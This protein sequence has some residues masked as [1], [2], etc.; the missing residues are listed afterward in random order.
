MF[1]RRLAVGFLAVG[2]LTQQGLA[3][4]R[5]TAGVGAASSPLSGG[6]KIPADGT[7]AESVTSGQVA[8]LVPGNPRNFLIGGDFGQNLWQRGLVVTAGGAG[9]LLADRWFATGAGLVMSRDTVA[10][11]LP[12]DVAA[13]GK[14]MPGGACIA[15]VVESADAAGAAGK[16]LE[17]A[18]WLSGVGASV[19]VVS[20]TGVDQG[21]ASW[22]AGGWSGQTV[23][24]TGSW[25]AGPSTFRVN[26]PAGT[27]ELAV[28]LCPS[29]TVTFSKLQLGVVGSSLVLP[30]L[31][32]TNAEEA[33]LQ[34]RFTW[35]LVEPAAGAVV[36]TGVAGSATVCNLAL[37]MQGM[38]TSPGYVNSLASGMFAIS[39]GGAGMPLASP[40]SVQLVSGGSIQ[41]TSSGLVA[42]AP[43]SLVGNGGGGLLLLDAEL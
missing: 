15:Q 3:A 9:A 22:L 6:E 42:G 25:G 39:Q 19:S 14:V 26:V 28:E 34:R 2:L 24:G 12:G 13:G 17:L 5:F 36:A 30:D 32:R 4:P 7:V 8:L 43:C 35:G 37:P 21:R 1:M 10:G 16:T 29:G 20:G 18:G 41:F 33:W 23:L 40:Y 38:R 11:D 27:Q 31:R